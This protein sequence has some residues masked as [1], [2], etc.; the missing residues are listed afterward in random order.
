MWQASECALSYF[1]VYDGH[2]GKDAAHYAA[3]YLHFNIARSRSFASDIVQGISEGFAITECNFLDKVG[4]AWSPL[5]L[6]I[7]SCYRVLLTQRIGMH[8]AGKTGTAGIREHG[9][10]STYQKANAVHC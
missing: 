8:R 3:K 10:R 1:G 6:C 5:Q 2:G 7:Y 4:T 9:L